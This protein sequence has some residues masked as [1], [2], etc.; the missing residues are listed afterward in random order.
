MAFST[1]PKQRNLHPSDLL[2]TDL[3]VVAAPMAGGPGTPALARAV[4]DAGGFPFL[5]AGYLSAESFADQMDA[6]R[7]LGCPFGV[8][9][10][11]PGPDDI[12]RESFTAYAERL[13]SDAD[14]YG[15]TL[16][17]VPVTGDL[18]AWPEKLDHLVA[19]PV[20]VVSL[21]FGLPDAT[22]IAALRRAGTRV[23]AT[24]T[25]PAEARAAREAG[26]D[27]LVVQGAAAGGHSATWEA[28][29][30]PRDIPT[31]DLVRDV[32]AATG[33]PVVAAGGVDGVTSVRRLREAGADAVAVGTLLLRTDEAGTSRTHRDA[34][35]DPDLGPPVITRAFTGRPARGLRNAFIDRHD[36]AAPV[37][38]PAI[39]HLTRPLRR[40]AADAG[41]A[42]RVHLWAG[43]GYR[44]ART[45]PAGAVI[46]GLVRAL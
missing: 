8:N 13:R 16:D 3:P 33:L 1:R 26:V 45:G 31:A 34:L 4:A 6:F 46:R 39:H 27:G 7:A 28:S 18:D 21:T 5:A 11:V 38:Y 42:D 30:T 40:A 25:T 37:G 2:G 20:P 17:P 24:V 35:T 44:N 23:L 14:R 29:R 32:V 10:F 22:D 19:D 36:A 9:L 15:L 12:D 41:D 43:T